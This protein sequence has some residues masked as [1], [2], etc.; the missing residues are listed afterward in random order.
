M[1]VYLLLA[2]VGLLLECF[3]E[4]QMEDKKEIKHVKFTYHR[5]SSL[6]QAVS[7]L[8]ETVCSEISHIYSIG[9]SV[10]NRHLLV[11]ALA[12]SS[13]QR[14]LLLRPEFKYAANMHGNEAIGREMLLHLAEHLCERYRG[15]DPVVRFILESTRV[16][17]LF[18]MNPDGFEGSVVGCEGPQRGNANGVDLNRY[19]FVLGFWLYFFCFYWCLKLDLNVLDYDFE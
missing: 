14:H 5:Y 10:E 7:E 4:S 2:Q 6:W 1:M 15:G 3:V 17:L 18:S 13:P 11:M 12:G 9:K 19:F 8:K 16:H